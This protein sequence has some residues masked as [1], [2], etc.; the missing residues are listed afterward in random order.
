M[1]TPTEVG[2]FKILASM[3]AGGEA[4]VFRALSPDGEVV[5][6]KLLAPE[7]RDDPAWRRRL[8]RECEAC[9]R[10]RH[11]NLVHLLE[12]GDDAQHGPYLVTRL[13]EGKTLRERTAGLALPPPLCY[14]LLEPLLHGLEAMHRAGFVH[15]DLKP[16]NVMVTDDGQVVIVDLGLSWHAERSRLTQEGCVAGSV[17]YM[18]PEQIQGGSI[19]TSC[20]VWSV[21][22]M[23]Y[24]L[25]SGQ[26]PFS[27]ELAGEEVAAILAGTH[28]PLGEADRRVSPDL[29]ALVEECLDP[30][31]GRRP[32]DATM[33]RARLEQ[34]EDHDPQPDLVAL[35]SDPRTAM[36]E[37]ADLQY[38]YWRAR[39]EEAVD[40][41]ESF[42]ALD[43]VDRALAYR[44]RQAEL[45]PLVDRAAKTEGKPGPRRRRRRRWAIV[46]SLGAVLAAVVAV[47][48]WAMVDNE[49]DNEAPQPPTEAPAKQSSPLIQAET[50]VEGAAGNSEDNKRSE[51]AE[52]KFY[53]TMGEMIRFMGKGARKKLD[54]E[55]GAGRNGRPRRAVV[56]APNNKTEADQKNA[57]RDDPPSKKTSRNKKA[58]KA[59]LD[60]V[61][62]FGALISDLAS[63]KKRA[64]G[65]DVSPDGQE[66]AVKMLG[67]LFRLMKEGAKGA[68][69]KKKKK[70]SKK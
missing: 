45:Q 28:A 51:A 2:G 67:G 6:L 24:E 7:H 10:L 22:V 57:A 12:S 1:S 65:V 70:V 36:E 41:G 13:L 27:R 31:P 64:E 55:A 33:L 40:A 35:V 9:A 17:P 39:A 50:G 66:A 8:E 29:S 69:K 43:A 52:R 60:V 34:L 25:V 16:E 37:A 32:A 11:P 49:V 21:G 54:A 58:D 56:E 61:D 18:S 46:A 5:A 3:G 30:E 53:G 14:L 68:N 62:G 47:G 59:A 4:R 20:D 26:R 42:R 48:G 44:P 38:A 63:G 23:L 19:T 15:R